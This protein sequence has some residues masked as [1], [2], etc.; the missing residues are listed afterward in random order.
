MTSPRRPFPLATGA[1]SLAFLFLLLTAPS[2][3]A[4]DEAAPTATSPADPSV[5]QAPPA[6]PDDLEIDR[7]EPDFQVIL[8]PTNLRLPK[9]KLAFGLTH[10]F[11]RPLGEGDFGDLLSD[12]FGFD[13]GAQIGLGLRFGL[14]SGT[15]LAFYRL[16]DRTIQF[17]VKTELLRQDRHAVGISALASVEG[18]ENFGL[19]ADDL[20]P[21]S[22][23]PRSPSWCP[24]SSAGTGPCTRSPVGWATRTSRRRT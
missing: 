3:A 2:T 15:Q 23:P 13:G 16:S 14:F 9:H 17:S 11:S 1:G 7:S 18:T 21:R 24:A 20:S 19:S 12:F 5:A 22:S 6:E 10:R 4:G 8:L